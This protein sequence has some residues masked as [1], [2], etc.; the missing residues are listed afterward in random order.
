M[1]ARF[2]GSWLDRVLSKMTLVT[3]SLPSFWLGILLLSLFSYWL[4][5]LPSS[6]M[7]SLALQEAGGLTAAADVLDHLALPAMTAAIPGA[8]ALARYLRTGI[9][10]T[11]K[12]EFAVAATG[13]G[14]PGG[15]VFRLY[16]LPNSVGPVVSLLGTEV[17]ILLTGILV[18][19]TLFAWPGMGRIAVMAVLARDYPMIMG[20]TLL[21]GVVVVA[22]NLLADI[23]RAW[24]DPR[25]RA[26]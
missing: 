4:R 7:H 1:A 8:A 22:A 11:L 13:M 14:L 15:K 5:I 24:I 23:V 9:A 3:Y 17:G 16:I 19:E 26:T 21:G 25:I 6:Q 2:L 20:C 10:E 18:T 12:E